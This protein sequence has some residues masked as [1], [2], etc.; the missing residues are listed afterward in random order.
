MKQR[1]NYKK[2]K[3]SLMIIEYIKINTQKI[4]KKN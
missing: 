3:K 4:S 1:Q 2:K